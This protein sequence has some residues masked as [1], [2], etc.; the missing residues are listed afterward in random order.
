MGPRA[1]ASRHHAVHGGD[2]PLMV[3]VTALRWLGLGVAAIAGAAAM[4]L[5]PPVPVSR[6][7]LGSGSSAAAADRS[8]ASVM[9]TDPI[10]LVM[11]AHN[12]LAIVNQ[13]NLDRLLTLESDLARDSRVVSVVGPGTVADAALRSASGE[14]HRLIGDPQQGIYG[15]YAYFVAALST[16]ALRSQGQTDPTTLARAAADAAQTATTELL[17]DL[18]RSA[19]DAHTARVSYRLA[20]TDEIVATREA[21]VNA[22]VANEPVPPHLADYLAAP[23]GQPDVGRAR[24]LVAEMGGAVGECDDQL[25]ALARTAVNC[26][27]FLERILLDLRRCPSVSS[28]AF[29]PPKSQWVAV[30]PPTSGA[31]QTLAVSVRLR[32]PTSAPAVRAL[33]LQALEHGVPSDILGGLDSAE[34]ARQR[35]QGPLMPTECGGATASVDPSCAS[36]WRDA[37]VAATLGGIP[38]SDR[39]TVDPDRLVAGVLMSLV[40]AGFAATPRR[41][42]T[43]RHLAAIATVAAAAVASVGLGTWVLGDGLS[44]SAL[45]AT[46]LV[47][48]WGTGIAGR[49]GTGRRSVA[50]AATGLMGFGALAGWDVGP[51]TGI[52]MLSHLAL[53]TGFGLASVRAAVGALPCVEV[54]QRPTPRP[55]TGR[56]RGGQWTVPLAVACAG[57]GTASAAGWGLPQPIVRTAPA[58]LTTGGAADPASP[59]S[60][61]DILLTGDVTGPVDGTNP[62]TAVVWQCALADAI[63]HDQASGVSGAWSIGDVLIGVN[64]E[65]LTSLRPCGPSAIGAAPRSPAAS[66][67]AAASGQSVGAQSEFIC[68]L[69]FVAELARSVAAPIPPGVSACPPR[70]LLAGTFLTTDP[71]PIQVTAARIVVAIRPSDEASAAALVER[72]A[73]SP[74]LAAPPP[75]VAATLAGGAARD[76][77]A[78]VAVGRWLPWTMAWLLLAAAALAVVDRSLRRIA[79]LAPAAIVV[80]VSPAVFG[81]VG[82]AS[83]TVGA[84]TPLSAVA[85][86]VMGAMTLPLVLAA[87]RRDY[88]A[89]RDDLAWGALFLAAGVLT[90]FGL[91]PI[92]I[93]A[94]SGFGAVFV[95]DLTFMKVVAVPAVRAL[96]HRRLTG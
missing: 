41:Q 69:R 7:L 54:A 5:G 12:P 70:D 1:I 93:P 74:V 59:A 37:P 16:K 27:P 36:L 82:A 42:R 21:A 52:P 72:I 23:A 88:E 86:P 11:T 32:D 30:L 28:H 45:V 63:S 10:T 18:T 81:L 26:V 71:S 15:E 79:A 49:R 68:E 84:V 47:M 46:P 90:L 35:A 17:D 91:L 96:V 50:A 73:A 2:R 76:A 62:P 38:L 43:R 57:C 66:P 39:A 83:E 33:I 34:I 80:I 60:E 4:A 25:A 77:A 55:R 78:H 67:L 92:G 6:A 3:Q 8:L 48:A 85:V 44:A 13:R 51:L 87:L 19:R 29:C 61:L 65:P 95:V 14:L 75:G 9:G 20:A 64:P 56:R 89:S 94:V 24:A 58:M 22:A 31:A 40:V 53:L